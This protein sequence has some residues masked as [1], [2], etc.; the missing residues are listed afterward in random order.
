MDSSILITVATLVV[1]VL[2]YFAGVQ[3]GRRERAEDRLESEIS[4]AVTRYRDISASGRSSGLVA[5]ST[6]GLELLGT[7]AAIREAIRRM[8][9]VTTAN[10]WGSDGEALVNAVDLV[11]FFRYVREQQVDWRYRPLPDVVA[12]VRRL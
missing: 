3:R 6:L 11:A 7:D 9:V 8:G 12:E 5:M 1:P 4:L 2:T 10:P